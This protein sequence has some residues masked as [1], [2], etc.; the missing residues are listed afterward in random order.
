MYYYCIFCDTYHSKEI[1]DTINRRFGVQTISP[2]VQKSH[3][4]KGKLEKIEKEML[5]GYVFLCTE[6]TMETLY[7]QLRSLTGV[8]RILGRLEDG[9]SLTGADLFFAEQLFRQ[10][11][12][13][14][15]QRIYKEGDRVVLKDNLFLGMHGTIKKYECRNARALVEFEFDGKTR[16]IWVAVEIVEPD[17]PGTMLPKDSSNQ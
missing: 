6:E 14:D 3:L 2:K 15:I 4:K 5:P 13:I 8:Y 1:A 17:D 12:L 9:F 7:Y 10:S 16:S 11:G